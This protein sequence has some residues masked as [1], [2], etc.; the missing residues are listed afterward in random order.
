MIFAFIFIL[1][2]SF[3]IGLPI[4]LCIVPRHNKVG[5]IGLSYLLGI[6][7]FTL[8]M[9]ITN[10]FGLKITALNNILL[11]FVLAVPFCILQKSN[12]KTFWESLKN[13]VKKTKFTLAEKVI[14]SI[15]AFWVFSSLINNLYWPV[16]AWDSLTLYDFRGRLFA[17]TGFIKDTLINLERPYYFAYPLLT[18]LSQTIVYLFGGENPRFL[19][20]MF[21]ISIGLV[22]YGQLRE[23]GN[24]TSSLIFTLMLMA[25]P[26][27][28]TQSF[29]S[30][31]NLPY[32]A[33]F[34]LGTIYVYL[35]DKKKSIRFLVLSAIMIGLSTWTR[36][37]EAFWLA[38]IV[39]VVIV[40]LY[41][42]KILDILIF[43]LFFYPIQQIWKIFQVTYGGRASTL[44][45]V[46]TYYNL[47]PYLFDF[48]R[49]ID[50]VQY[51]YENIV[52]PW[53]GVFIV[54]LVVILGYRNKK[55]FLMVFI[56]FFLIVFFLVG[57]FIFSYIN[58]TWIEIP[59][60]AERVSM[61][62]Y[63]FFVFSIASG[64]LVEE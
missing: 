18:S 51:F 7:I 33:Y 9:F 13:S 53:G 40:S 20:T 43:C 15:I 27:I 54:F 10:L 26:R 58:K 50:V 21:Y 31:T 60:S 14:I 1:L 38:I 49:W 23:F 24:R 46:N 19:Y 62:F 41:R 5:C 6:G 44:V 3:G 4:T 17:Q 57:T 56:T 8:L 28:F 22:F 11:F 64:L 12:I 32:V 25:V 52:V 47:T 48:K 2:I 59:D 39:L 36:S 37:S 42:K 45:E 30:Y 16:Y 29:I 61:I 55:S 63:P 34:S 35:W